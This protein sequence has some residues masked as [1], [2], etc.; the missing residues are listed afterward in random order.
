MADTQEKDTQENINEVIGNADEEA[1]PVAHALPR[2]NTTVVVDNI[3]KAR[4][5]ALMAAGIQA[6]LGVVIVALDVVGFTMKADDENC[7]SEPLSWGSFYLVHAI[8]CVV[9]IL[10]NLTFLFALSLTYNKYLATALIHEAKGAMEEAAKEKKSGEVW[11]NRGEK[12]L[13]PVCCCGVC[14]LIIFS[15]VWFIMGIVTYTNS[16]SKACDE[17]KNWLWIILAT[18]LVMQII[19]NIKPKKE[20]SSGEVAPLMQ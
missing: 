4:N 8:T 3:M 17:A 14:P 18:H 15:L 7:D 12:I 2:G 11:K 16:N 19:A 1:P 10:L 20:K 6:L 9:G 5:R 13:L